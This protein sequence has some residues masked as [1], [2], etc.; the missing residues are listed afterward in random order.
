MERVPPATQLSLPFDWQG[1]PRFNPARL[2][3]AR[4]LRMLTQM[5]L[6]DQAGLS[7]SAISHFET[8]RHDPL[9]DT[10][11]RLACA[12]DVPSDFLRRDDALT[13]ALATGFFRADRRAS[14]PQKECL[15]RH[16][17]L[18]SYILDAVN[19]HEQ[20]APA[21]PALPAVGGASDPEHSAAELRAAWAIVDGPLPNAVRLAEEHGI[22][23]VRVRMPLPTMDSFSVACQPR[24]VIALGSTRLHTGRNRFDVCHELGH[25][26][27]HRGVSLPHGIREKQADLFASSLLMPSA[28]ITQELPARFDLTQYCDLAMRWRVSPEA[29]IYRSAILGHVT[30]KVY[31]AARRWLRSRAPE[32]PSTVELP[33]TTYQLLDR[34]LDRSNIDRL[35]EELALTADEIR[36]FVIHSQGGPLVLNPLL[37]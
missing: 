34:A 18:L 12:L 22:L 24:P 33:T 23:V 36:R 5:D 35:A 21:A 31:L 28:D 10:V 3:F 4:Q 14:E 9:P 1:L 19:Q 26:V 2:L 29:L 20:L 17:A 25:L 16:L 8:G 32:E 6:A 37:L 7:H 30:K 13:A 15:S 11:E 27:M